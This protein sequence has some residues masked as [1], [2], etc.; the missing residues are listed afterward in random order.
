MAGYEWVSF[1]TDYGTSDGFVA[2]CHGVI[3]RL[4]PTLR[5]IDVTHEVPPGDVT[6]AAAVL[7]QTVA[8][9]PRAVHLAVVDPGVGTDRRGVAL[10]TPA[11]ILVGP[12]NG[13]LPWAAH[14][15]GGI[16]AAVELANPDWWGSPVSRT[17]HGRDVF[18]P[19]A[20]HLA[21]GADIIDGGPRVDT[22]TLVQL[23][24]PVV[25]TGDG[26]LESEVLTVDRFGNVQLA[27]GAATLA[28]LGGSLQVGN[29]P[30]VRGG[31]F[32]DAPRGGLVVLTDSAGHLSISVNGGRAS[33]LLRATPGD[34][35]RISS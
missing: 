33:V 22:A 3:A 13:L 18:A 6:R 11:G 7:A 34:I 4:A 14:A 25:R 17:F 5:I 19:A 2:V 8:H 29:A 24:D 21:A 35:V 1:T 27:A 31:T 30:A 9:L 23:P 20:A 15:L 12:D 10:A 28:H 32:A 16:T 26:W